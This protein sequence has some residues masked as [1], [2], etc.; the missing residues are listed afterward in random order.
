MTPDGSVILELEAARAFAGGFAPDLP[1]GAAENIVFRSSTSLAAH[2]RRELKAFCLD[3]VPPLCGHLGIIV[4][5]PLWGSLR[6]GWAMLTSFSSTAGMIALLREL[7]RL[8]ILGYTSVM[9]VY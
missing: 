9:L 3:V 1:E 8:L 5:L 6:E 7:K 2:W 4:P